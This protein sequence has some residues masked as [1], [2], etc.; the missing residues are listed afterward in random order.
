MD[1]GR[2]RPK[3]TLVRKMESDGKGRM[4]R[5]GEPLEAKNR[6]WDKKV[7][8]FLS[9]A[10]EIR[11][12]GA[13]NKPS[14]I[15]GLRHT[16]LKPKMNTFPITPGL[17][18]SVFRTT[19]QVSSLLKSITKALVQTGNKG[20]ALPRCVRRTHTADKGGRRALNTSHTNRWNM[21]SKKEAF[22]TMG[23]WRTRQREVD[24]LQCNWVTSYHWKQLSLNNLTVKW[25]CFHCMDYW[26]NLE[27]KCKQFKFTW[28]LKVWKVR[29]IKS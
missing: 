13:S 15:I 26:L 12:R 18:A 7:Y 8:S 6:R 29:Q 28:I 23:R 10:V 25:S 11:T 22:N 3:I 27:R 5:Y 1:G 21:R 14:F 2:S 4:E 24:V 16:H 9:C 20:A 17:K 19:E